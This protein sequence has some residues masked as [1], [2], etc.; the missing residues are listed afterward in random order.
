MSG[1]RG[2]H[3]QRIQVLE[4][5]YIDALAERTRIVA[6]LDRSIL[7]AKNELVREIAVEYDVPFRAIVLGTRMC[8]ASPT[9]QCIYNYDDAKHR[10]VVCG[11]PEP[12]E[13]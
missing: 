2:L 1:L 12:K 11:L 8:A 10:C 9:E 4:A 6:P 3:F 7:Q 5:R 13:K